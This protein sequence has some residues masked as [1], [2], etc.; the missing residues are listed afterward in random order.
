MKIN[1][2]T[3]EINGV[4]E[5]V[6]VTNISQKESLYFGLETKKGNKHFCVVFGSNEIYRGFGHTIEEAICNAK[7][8]N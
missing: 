5:S 8:V 4:K 2:T 7:K 3:K 6:M 1:Y